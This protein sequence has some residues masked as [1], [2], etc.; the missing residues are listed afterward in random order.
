MFAM[1]VVLLGTLGSLPAEHDGV[2]VGADRV[3]PSQTGRPRCVGGTDEIVVCGAREREAAPYRIDPSVLAAQRAREAPPVDARSPQQKAVAVSC[4]DLPSK[5]QGSGTIPLL[6]VALKAAEAALL[7]A[8]GED[9]RSPFRT[10]PDEYQLHQQDKAK[11]ARIS[12][13]LGAGVKR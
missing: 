6:P 2:G 5:C 13:G 4:H 9:W 1:G 3:L 11:R 8:K 12:I 10:G 7:A